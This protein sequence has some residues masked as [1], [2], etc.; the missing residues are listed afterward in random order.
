MNCPNCNTENKVTAKFCMNCGTKLFEEQSVVTPPPLPNTGSELSVPPPLPQVNAQNPSNQTQSQK[1]QQQNYTNSK[2]SNLLPVFLVLGGIGAVIGIIALLVN[3]N[4]NSYDYDSV[5]ATVE[6]S[7]YENY[8]GVEEA[9]AAMEA[10]EVPVVAA[11]EVEAVD[12]AE[13]EA[14]AVEGVVEYRD[15]FV[16]VV[17]VDSD[18]DIN[19]DWIARDALKFNVD[20]EHCHWCGKKINEENFVASFHYRYCSNKC[21]SEAGDN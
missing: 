12:A 2:R 8:E 14:E 5:E 17:A 7:A 16:E 18:S 6:N 10:T 15:P 3:L 4:E 11:A 20:K 19:I 9:E 21:K 13:A 1:R